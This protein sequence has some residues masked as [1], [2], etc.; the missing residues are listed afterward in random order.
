[1]IIHTIETARR[2]VNTTLNFLAKSEYT[3]DIAS[4]RK[5]PRRTPFRV[6]QSEGNDVLEI[7]AEQPKGVEHVAEIAA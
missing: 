6:I 4:K 3:A 1:M 7:I 5:M 2:F